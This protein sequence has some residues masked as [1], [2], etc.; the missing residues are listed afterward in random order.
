MKSRKRWLLAASAITAATLVFTGCA[1]SAPSPEPS[2][3]DEK[4]DDKPSSE[5]SPSEEEPADVEEPAEGD[6]P[7]TMSFEDGAL[8]PSDAQLQWADSMFT[9]DEYVVKSEDNG[10][11]AWSYTRIASGCDIAFWQGQMTDLA[12]TPDDRQMTV[13]LI[14]GVLQAPEEK[15]TEVAIQTEVDYQLSGA[16]G[17]DALMVGGEN[18]DKTSW[19]L[20][21]RAFHTTSMSMFV[22]INCPAGTS[23]QDEFATVGANDLGIVVVPAMG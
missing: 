22:T 19:I 17:V 12:N 4:P 6:L 20:A 3:S 15:V 21:A 18:D 2:T 14:A 8:L 5:P 10:Q 23:A 1:N 11:G 7:E 16:G 9:N 13:E